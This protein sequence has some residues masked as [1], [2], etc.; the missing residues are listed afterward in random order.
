MPAEVRREAL[1]KAAYDQIAAR[2]FEGLRTREIA[3]AAGVNIATLHYYFPTK[4]A[5]I[6]AVV[7]HAMGR[8]RT[9]L[10][11]G[12]D[13]GQHLRAVRNFL[14]DEPELRAVMGELSLRATRD[15]ALAAILQETYATWQKTMRGLLRNAVRAGRLKPE[16]DS[17]ETAAAVMATMSSLMLPTMANSPVADQALKQLENWLSIN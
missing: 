1:V 2:G 5:L 10:E 9:T 8:F 15:P 4:E 14:K 12:P 11:G 16:L 3:R 7:E 6:K 17:D 13:L